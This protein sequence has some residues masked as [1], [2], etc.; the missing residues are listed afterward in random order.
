MKRLMFCLFAILLLVGCSSEPVQPAEPETRHDVA[1]YE[2]ATLI[3]G[4]GAPVENAAMIVDNGT[5]TAL[6]P[7]GG[8]PAP[9]GAARVDLSG[10]TIMPTMVN[11]HGH[12]G[13]LKGV[14]FEAKNYSRE[15]IIDDL[16]RYVYY[17]V[18]AVQVLGTDMGDAAFQ[19]REEQR[20]GRLGGATYFTAGRGFTAKGGFPAAAIP[21]MKDAPYQVSSEEEA[22]KAVQ[23]LAVQKVDMIKMWVDD[24]MGKQPKLRPNISAAIID[25]AHKNNIRVMAHLFYLN[26]AKELVKAGL[27]GIAHSVR[28]REVDDALIAALKEKNVWY[29]PTLTGHE[30]VF[31]FA[32]K[33]SWIGEPAMREGMAAHVIADLTGDAFVNKIK[34]NPDVAKLRQHYKMALKNLKKLS[35]A[36]VRIAFGTDSGS[37]NRFIG[38][39]EHRELELMVAA[40]LTPEQAIVAATKTSAEILGLKDRGTLAVGKSADFII[41]DASPLEDIVNSRGIAQVFVAGKELDRAEM[42]MRQTST[43]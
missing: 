1:Y 42:M 8:I 10:K 38:Y 28:D 23:E 30:S 5:I 24:N 31:T 29:V 13:Y 12:A 20:Q 22:R 39:F 7:K 41:L 6:G 33:P 43:Q 9:K 35:D 40:G 16:N 32:D 4:E 26:D 36:G 19:I 21:A 14:N 34:Q 18:G 37:M 11:L 17:G 27:D 3:T 15:S 25:E 2:N